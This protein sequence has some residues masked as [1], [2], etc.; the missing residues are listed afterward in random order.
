MSHYQKHT[1]NCHKKTCE[2]TCCLTANNKHCP[3]FLTTAKDVF[4]A[5]QTDGSKE[6][7]ALFLFVLLCFLICDYVTVLYSGAVLSFFLLL[8]FSDLFLPLCLLQVAVAFS[9]FAAVF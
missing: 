3:S 4:C 5:R 6:W 2:Q 7:D 9:C 1:E 8:C